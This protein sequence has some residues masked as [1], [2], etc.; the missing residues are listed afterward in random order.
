MRRMFEDVDTEVARLVAQRTANTVN[1]NT[2]TELY[3]GVDFFM[4]KEQLEQIPPLLADVE[5]TT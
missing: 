2:L 1:I 5:P 4:T 3:D